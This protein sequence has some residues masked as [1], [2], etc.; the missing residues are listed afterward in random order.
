MQSKY[1]SDGCWKKY[2]QGY[3]DT[4]HTSYNQNRIE[5]VKSLLN[6]VK[7]A[8][9]GL[10]ALDF[11][12]GDGTFGELIMDFCDHVAFV[13]IDQTMVSAATKRL[14]DKYGHMSAPPFSVNLGD[15]EFL[16]TW[17]DNC[18]DLVLAINVLAYLKEQE[19]QAFYKHCHRIL[20]PNGFL[21]VTH[22]NELFDMYTFNK[23][24]VRFFQK[25]FALYEGMDNIGSLITNPEKPDRVPHPVREN[26]LC[27]KFKLNKYGFCETQQDFA[28]LHE[29]PPLLMPN[30]DP[31]DLEARSCRDT[32]NIPEHEKWK[33]MF[34]CSIFGSLSAC[35]K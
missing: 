30:F 15:T 14:Q 27:Y 12:C 17:P 8:G 10:R 2:A 11:G 34:M 24:T 35:I 31:D 3:I 20:R 7:P 21:I 25:N 13:D 32:I 9:G 5:M 23:Y 18:F 22:S 6:A 19:E 33:L 1:G 16:Q 28:I 29:Q 4:M 26:P